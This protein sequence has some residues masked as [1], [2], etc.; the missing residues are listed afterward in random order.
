MYKIGLVLNC[1]GVGIYV[2][3]VSSEL[4]VVFVCVCGYAYLFKIDHNQYY[5]VLL[6][7]FMSVLVCSSKL[8][9]GDF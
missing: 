7:V 8:I 4:D 9:Y 2:F 5:V 3:C 1:D 6:S